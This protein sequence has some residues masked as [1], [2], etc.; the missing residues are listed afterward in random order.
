MTPRPENILANLI[1][2][3][4][5]EL[6]DF[7]VLTI[8]GLATLEDLL[9]E[10]VG[11]IRDEYDVEVERIIDEALGV[12]ERTGVLIEDERALHRL[13]GVGLGLC[14]ASHGRHQILIGRLLQ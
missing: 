11:E 1:A 14:Q 3:R 8:E 4:A 6:P 10:I 7:D 2:N 13:A 5:A 9:E 12:L